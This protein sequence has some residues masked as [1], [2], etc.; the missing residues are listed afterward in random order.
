MYQPDTIPHQ[1]IG[2]PSTPLQIPKVKV[3]DMGYVDNPWKRFVSGNFESLPVVHELHMPNIPL[4][5]A[6][7]RD[8]R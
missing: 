8:K 1:T 4:P 5:H 7:N 6:G 3:R 2:S